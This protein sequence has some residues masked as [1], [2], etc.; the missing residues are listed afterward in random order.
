MPK[1]RRKKE[2]REETPVLLLKGSLYFWTERP[3]MRAFLPFFQ[4]GS[5]HRNLPRCLYDDAPPVLFS[6]IPSGRFR[7][8]QVAKVLDVEAEKAVQEAYG[9]A[10]KFGNAQVGTLHLFLGAL[11]SPSV[12]VVFGRLGL[13]FDSIR[14]ALVR[15]LSD[16]PPQTRPHFTR[17]A[18]ESVLASCGS[19]FLEGRKRVSPL[20][21]LEEAYRRDACVQ[22]LLHDLGVDRARFENV[23]AWVRIDARR[24]EYF[25]PLGDEATRPSS[26]KTAHRR[27][28]STVTPLLDQYAQDLTAQAAAGRLPLLIGRRRE[29]E[30]IFQVLKSDA[31]RAVIL[32]GFP[33]TG[34]RALLAGLAQHLV[35]EMVPAPL[36][37]KRLMTLSLSSFFLKK[38]SSDSEEHFSHLLS[39]V[40]QTGDVI[41]V[42]SDLEQITE[43][44]GKLLN[45]LVQAISNGLRAVAVCDSE[46]YRR[47]VATSSLGLAFKRLVVEEPGENEAIRMLESKIGRIEAR[48]GMFFS[49]E[50]V[51][52]CVA[53]SDRYL[54]DRCLPLKAIELAEETALDA[55]NSQGSNTLI[56]GEDVMRSIL[57]KMKMPLGRDDGSGRDLLSHLEER[58]Q[59]GI[60]GRK[61]IVHAVAVALQRARSMQREDRRPL[62]S[63]LFLGPK[64]SEKAAFAKT[65][66][67]VFFGSEKAWVPLEMSGGQGAEEGEQ[68]LGAPEKE[69]KREVADLI[70]EDPFRILFLQDLEEFSP[71]F[72]ASFQRIMTEGTLEDVF[73][74]TIDFSN[75]VLIAASDKE[76]DFLRKKG[77]DWSAFLDCFDEIVVFG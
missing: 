11:S 40:Q 44:K 10:V 75:T 66:A 71:N 77:S 74:R 37:H 7:H 52:K 13:S 55:R 8:R 26:R 36:Q 28:M 43:T 15:R 45:L 34:R 59:Q 57:K 30:E 3:D 41:L 12:A 49:F 68:M 6:Q 23:V 54:H 48:Q 70:Q 72:L 61:E 51:E 29:L 9:L 64:N 24:R 33:G 47:E 31:R 62:I 73:G 22:A 1:E 69:K 20:R 4:R 63:F 18:V 27:V 42:L 58:L 5:G 50:A 53:L 19:A 17:E 67:E 46:L 25:E 65:I 21:L 39:E 38:S 32:V 2:K 60:P 35:E 16:L 14:A 56:T 76:M